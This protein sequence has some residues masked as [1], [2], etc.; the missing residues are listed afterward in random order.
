M[1]CIIFQGEEEEPGFCE[2]CSGF[3]LFPGGTYSQINF[4]FYTQ[5]KKTSLTDSTILLKVGVILLCVAYAVL[6]ANTFMSME[7]PAEEQRYEKSHQSP[8]SDMLKEY[9][10]A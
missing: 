5:L 9:E 8:S 1:I 3:R 10:L 2:N 4:F 6:G 7:G